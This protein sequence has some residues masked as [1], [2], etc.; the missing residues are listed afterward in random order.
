MSEKLFKTDKDLQE[1]VDAYFDEV[2][3]SPTVTGLAFHL[4]FTSRQ[5]F[6]DYENNEIHSYTIKRAR[7]RIENAYE[8]RLHG[9]SNA[10]AIFAL[11]NFG[12]SDKQEIEHTGKDGS[13]IEFTD[14]ARAA[15]L[16]TI[17]ERGR[18]ARDRQSDK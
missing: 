7:V 5:S 9:N 10:G 13:A 12:W 17:L 4:G 18:E 8:T 2:G 11:K 1:A 14:T 15:R 6:Y 3:D 16:A